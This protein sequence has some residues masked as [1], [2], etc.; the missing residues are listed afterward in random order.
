M[1]D[2]SAAQA[3]VMEAARR[4]AEALIAGNVRGPLIWR[5]QRLADVRLAVE[6]D[7]AVLAAVVHDE[8]SRDGQDQTFTLRLTQTWVRTAEG[9]RCLAGHASLPAG[10]AE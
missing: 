4:R 6:A 1:A 8:V 7:V 10:P 5:G 2:R 9:W 3:E